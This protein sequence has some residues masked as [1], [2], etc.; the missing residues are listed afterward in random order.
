MNLSFDIQH[1][2]IQDGIASIVR[3]NIQTEFTVPSEGAPQHAEAVVVEIARR[4]T[5]HDE[6]FIRERIQEQFWLDGSD[7]PEEPAK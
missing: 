1:E 4:L 6:G 5:G 7:R 2:V 3:L